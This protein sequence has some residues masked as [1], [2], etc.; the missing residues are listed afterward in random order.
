[1]GRS[2]TTRTLAY[3]TASSRARSDTP[4]SSAARATATSSRTRRH[5][6][7]W[8]PWGPRG[9]TGSSSR[10]RRASL[11]VGSRQGTASALGEAS[12]NERIP[13]SASATTMTQSAVWPS[14][15]I[16]LW[17]VTTQPDPFRRA[18]A[19]TVAS[20]WP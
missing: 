11:R 17:P 13:S 10:T 20:G 3:S 6:T 9:S 5:S 8:S 19:R 2:N 4:T 7:V 14:T 18:R 1:M 16:G 15:T 12:R